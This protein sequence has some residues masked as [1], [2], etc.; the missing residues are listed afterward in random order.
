M[1][2]A[3]YQEMPVYPRKGYVKRIGNSIVVK[4]DEA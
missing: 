2:E 3:T 1:A 4:L